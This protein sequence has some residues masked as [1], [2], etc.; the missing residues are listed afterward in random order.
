MDPSPDSDDPFKG[1]ISPMLRDQ[2]RFEL[3]SDLRGVARFRRALRKE[4]QDALD[5]LLV[6]ID[7]Q[8]HLRGQA[9]H[10]TPLEFMLIALLIEEHK[11][12]VDLRRRVDALASASQSD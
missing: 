3:D 5:D 1:F 11:L 12:V 7:N 8:W 10:L 2:S 6:A 9:S 4:D